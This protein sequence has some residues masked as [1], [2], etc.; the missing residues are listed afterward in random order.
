MKEEKKVSASTAVIMVLLLL[1]FLVFSF[2]VLYNMKDKNVEN[3]GETIN[4][5]I[6]Q[7]FATE[8]KK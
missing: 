2:L 7:N 5:N 4:D 3:K 8:D 1:I 6:S